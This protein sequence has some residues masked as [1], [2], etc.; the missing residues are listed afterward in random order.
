MHGGVSAGS[1]GAGRPCTCMLTQ[2]PFR[3]MHLLPGVI[4]LTAAVTQLRVT[5]VNRAAAAAGTPAVAVAPT[6]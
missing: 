4:G 1:R 2:P 5:A 3:H 6:A